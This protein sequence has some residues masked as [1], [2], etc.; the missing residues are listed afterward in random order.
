[1]IIVSL[2]LNMHIL[3]LT[4]FIAFAHGKSVPT[5]CINNNET[6]YVG[7]WLDSRNSQ[8]FASFQ[9]I[10]YAMPPTG[11]LR[12]KPPQRY[13]PG[14]KTFMVDQKWA[15][16][17]PQQYRDMYTED[18]D[19]IIAGIEDCLFL[20]VYV[21]EIALINGTKLPVMVWI[22]GGSLI[23][24]SGMVNNYLTVYLLRQFSI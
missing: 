20:N 4:F 2:R 16:N 3:I 5:V 21:P 17:C 6:C 18:D 7:A 23:T 8:P 15:V 19:F 11:D 9:G 1:M 12:F 10:K 14:K 13:L 24:G 22:H